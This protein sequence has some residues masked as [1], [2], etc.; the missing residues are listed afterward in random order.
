MKKLEEL[1]T[2]CV[3]NVLRGK[4]T[5]YYCDRKCTHL[6]VVNKFGVVMPYCEKHAKE[7]AYDKKLI[8]KIPK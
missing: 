4:C 5:V 8:H 1:N 2:E 7:M 6:A 3:N